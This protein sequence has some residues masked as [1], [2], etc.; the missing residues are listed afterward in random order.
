MP[1]AIN[2]QVDILRQSFN[3]NNIPEDTVNTHKT[4]L[5]PLTLLSKENLSLGYLH[6]C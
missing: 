6:D 4:F 3:L 1:Y 5:A 2:H